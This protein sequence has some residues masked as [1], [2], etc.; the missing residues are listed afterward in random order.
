MSDC[1]NGERPGSVTEFDPTLS[2]RTVHYRPTYRS[3][4]RYDGYTRPPSTSVTDT[5]LR[6][7][8]GAE[9]HCIPTPFQSGQI[10]SGAPPLRFSFPFWQ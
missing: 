3:Y 7:A 10:G 4:T 6:G 1:K 5:V 9:R 2:P 8:G